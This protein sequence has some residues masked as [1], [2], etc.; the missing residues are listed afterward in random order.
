MAVPQEDLE[1]LAE[2]ALKEF[3]KLHCSKFPVFEQLMRKNHWLSTE[4]NLQE[5]EASVNQVMEGHGDRLSADGRSG[6]G[7]KLAEYRLQVMSCNWKRGTNRG[8]GPHL[9]RL[10]R[11]RYLTRMQL[12]RLEVL[13]GIRCI[14]QH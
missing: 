2:A 9:D 11:N 10:T 4:R 8:W 12:V 6:L 14:I 7:A 1:G 5:L 13:K 3:K